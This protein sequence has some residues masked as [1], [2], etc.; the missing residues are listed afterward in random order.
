MPEDL[1]FK[2]MGAAGYER[3]M[4]RW[5]QRL[6]APFLDFVGTADDERVLDVGCGTGN[7]TFAICNRAKV[8]K[9]CGIDLSPDFIDRADELNNDP[10]IEF[11]V[12]DASELPYDDASFDRVLSQLVLQFVPDSNNAIAEMRRVARPGAVVAATTWDTRGGF[13][14]NRMF[15]DTAAMVDP[16]ANKRRALNYSRPLSRPGDLSEAWREAGFVDVV[17]TMLPIR[18][19]FASFEDYW[20][21]L[22]TGGGPPADY[23]RSIDPEMQ[24]KVRD[25]VE[26]AY[27]DGEADGPRSYVAIAWSVKGKVP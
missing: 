15:Y 14:A 21:P 25:A 2:P 13:V 24:A 6:A 5:S 1:T 3:Q 17:D 8:Q 26:R 7:L 4:G 12:G 19:D 11:R 20:I 22:S 16:E 27:L 10:K 18:M 23:V 9:A